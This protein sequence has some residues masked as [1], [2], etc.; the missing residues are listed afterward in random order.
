MRVE[1]ERFI[2]KER[3]KEAVKQAKLCYK[4][5]NSPE[6]HRLLERAYFLRAGQLVQFGMRASAV[7]VAQHLL[8]FGVTTG[9]WTP[10]LVRLLMSLGLS[11]GAFEIQGR[12]GAPE[13]KDQLVVMAADEAVIHPERAAANAPEIA[14]DVSLIRQS[15]ERL[16]ARDEEGTFLQLRDLARSSMLSEWKFFIRGLAAYYRHDSDD[17]KANWDRLD[18]NR[19]AFPIAQRLLQLAKNEGPGASSADI[20]AMEKLAFGEPVLDRLRQVCSLAASHEW[21][22]VF[23]VLGALRLS[24]RRIDPKLAERLTQ[25]LIGSVIKEAES[26]D[27]S[28]AE[29]LVRGFTRATEPMA[30]DPNWNRL[31]GMIWDGPQASSSGAADYWGKYI[32]DLKTVTVL[33]SSERALAQA[34][35]W[36]HLAQLHR[37][38]VADL[39][40]SDA[41][42]GFPLFRRTRSGSDPTEVARSRERV[43]DCLEQSLELAPEH[44]PTYESLVEVYRDWDEPDKLE[45]AAR[46][47]LNK[48]PDDLETL[49]L[50]ANHYTGKNE[51]PPPC[52]TSRRRALSSRSTTRCAHWSGP[53][54]SAWPAI[55]LSLNNGTKGATS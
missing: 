39:T 55:T 4:E 27:L 11:G 25:A 42:L 45:T 7:E 24:L 19:K 50:L 13:L 22:K 12:F 5:E 15:L 33:N 1:V 10:E 20:E 14:R 40:R 43:V 37:T 18:P 49:T 6:N 47:L 52:R 51:L 21:E 28:G 2:A 41:P 35:I 48:F 3:Y 9:D 31:W 8:D 26:L 32:D 16:Q 17:I 53:S 46:R 44:R 34:M 38:C 54:A 23:R 36:N 29:R 30:I